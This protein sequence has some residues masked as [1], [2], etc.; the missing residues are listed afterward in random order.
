M[1]AN[2]WEEVGNKCLT[3]ALALLDEKTAPTGATVETVHALVNIAIEIDCLNLRWAE[4]SRYGG[5]AFQGHVCERRPIRHDAPN[6]P[7]Q[8]PIPARK[9]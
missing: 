1:G 4:Q 6:P 8:I 5:A 9:R 7:T 2:M 3:H